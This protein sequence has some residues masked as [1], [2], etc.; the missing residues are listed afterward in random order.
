MEPTLENASMVW[1]ALAE[2]VETFVEAWETL[3]RPPP[4]EDHLPPEPPVL[5]KLTLIELIKVDLEYRWKENS[6]KSIEEYA[7]EFPELNGESGPPAD[8]I[9]EEYHIRRAQGD[10]VYAEDYFDRFP[11]QESRLRR[12]LGVGDPAASTAMCARRP[13][14][15]L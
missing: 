7:A 6:P 2:R 9:Y 10:T 5:R 15:E 12:L 8:L 3:R 1:D 4:L 13:V 11:Q 14:Q